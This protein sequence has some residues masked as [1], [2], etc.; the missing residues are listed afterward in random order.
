MNPQSNFLLQKAAESI[1]KNQ[2]DVAKLYLVQLQKIDPKNSEAYRYLGVINAKMKNYSEALIMLNK[3]IEINPNNAIAYSN[4]GNV[5][6][7]LKNSEDAIKDYQIAI[8]KNK[9]YP[10]TYTNLGNALRD[11]RLLQEALVSHTKAIQLDQT[12]ADYWS[13]R[14]LTLFEMKKYEEA[15]F[16]FE[17]A[18]RLNA[19]HIEAWVNKANI[20]IHRN[21]LEEAEE[22]I[23]I[24]LQI[25]TKHQSALLTLGLINSKSR[26][27]ENAIKIYSDLIKSDPNYAEA[28]HNLALLLLGLFRFSEGW[29]EYDWR[30]SV[31][32][33]NSSYLQT[34]KKFWDG[35]P[36]NSRI[37]IWAEQGIGDQILYSS[38]LADLI[39]FPNK[40][41]ISVHQ[42]LLPLFK[43]S[44]P[45]FEVI[46]DN[47]ALSE[48]QYD[49]HLPIAS[50]LKFFRNSLEDFKKQK[51]PYLIPDSSKL[52]VAQLQQLPQGLV[53]GISWRSSNEKVGEEKSMPLALLEPIL[54][55]PGVVPV[56]LQYGDVEEEITAA[57]R[58]TGSSI[59]QI[60]DLDVYDDID[61]LLALIDRC[62]VV[63]TTSNSTAH[64]AGAIG[65]ETYLITP[66]ARGKFWY[67]HDLEGISLWYPSIKIFK[68]TAPGDWSHPIQKIASIIGN[69]I[70]GC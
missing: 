10:D 2:L 58:E 17:E 29:L 34:S 41:I 70:E 62:D 20:S 25:D 57:N 3:A 5:L 39:N 33:C 12:N 51:Y 21:K 63:V 22:I 15:L 59:I 48:S 7:F 28:H 31:S 54:K 49:E 40:K 68:Q 60:K 1:Q 18:I 27:F 30:W 8:K 32:E 46:P 47:L 55:L 9:N 11:K 67:W 65:K 50:L 19:K 45:E 13:N 14:G 56:N 38:A 4:R 36:S 35:K 44:F 42:K 37:F 16:H 61:G 43:R 24:A 69:Q 23:N 26:N 66:T 6:R 52:T 64:L 53:C